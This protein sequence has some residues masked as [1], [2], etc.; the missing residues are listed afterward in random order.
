MRE[1]WEVRKMWRD[2]GN[3]KDERRMGGD[4][5]VEMIEM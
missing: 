3:V 4:G 5:N 2:E 1:T